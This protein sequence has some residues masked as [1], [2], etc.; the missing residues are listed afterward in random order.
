MQ[1]RFKGH[2]C[3]AYKGWIKQDNICSFPL[4]CLQKVFAYFTFLSSFIFDASKKQ[5]KQW[6]KSPLPYIKHIN[7]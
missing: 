6:N 5:M 1:G 3:T 2:H 4:L 7:L